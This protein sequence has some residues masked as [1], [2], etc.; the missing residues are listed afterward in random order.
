MALAPEKH[1]DEP[2]GPDSF[3]SPAPERE[4]KNATPA[5]APQKWIIQELVIHCVLYRES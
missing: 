4:M 1:N 3:P 2:F 5:P